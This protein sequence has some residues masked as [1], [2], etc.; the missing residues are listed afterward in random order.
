MS[1]AE[2]LRVVLKKA[3]RAIQSADRVR[4]TDPDTAVSRLYYSMF[5][6]ATSLLLTKGLGFSKHKA[7]ISAFAQH[8]VK[9]GL[10]PQEFHRW[11]LDAFKMR[12][13]SDYQFVA[14]PDSEAIQDLATK[15][16]QF[17][18]RTEE[19]LKQGGYL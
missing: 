10:L 7:V 4:A 13:V 1:D 6:C 8:F 2:E 9:T 18:A 19:F 15:A 16:E 12:Q 17:L 3:H 14:P 5:Y 11:I